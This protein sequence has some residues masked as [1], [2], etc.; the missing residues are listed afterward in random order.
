MTLSKKRRKAVVVYGV[1]IFIV[2]LIIFFLP[3]CANNASAQTENRVEFVHLGRPEG[4]R[5]DIFYFRYGID[6][7]YLAVSPKSATLACK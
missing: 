3:A 2:G 5:V 1:T 6:D 7:C 4:W